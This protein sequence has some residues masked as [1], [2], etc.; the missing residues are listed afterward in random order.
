MAHGQ[1]AGGLVGSAVLIVGA[2]RKAG[3]CPGGESWTHLFAALVRVALLLWL[4]EQP[5][6]VF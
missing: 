3:L 4:L 1:V 6:F 2:F 5:L